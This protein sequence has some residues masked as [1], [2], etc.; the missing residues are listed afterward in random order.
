SYADSDTL[1]LG[2]TEY[3]RRARERILA[4]NPGYFFDSPNP[5]LGATTNIRSADGSPLFGPGTANF[6]SVPVGYAGGGGLAPL[7][8]HAGQ[9]NLESPRTAQYPGGAETHVLKGSRNKSAAATVRR[10][11]SANVDAFVELAAAEGDSSY[12]TIVGLNTYT[13]PADA[14]NNPFGQAVRVTVPLAGAVSQSSASNEDRRVMGGVIVKLPGRWLAEADYT[15]SEASLRIV[16]P[17]MAFGAIGPISSGSIDV[18]RDL[19]AYPV[20]FASY[21]SPAGVNGP[22]RSTLKDATVRF[23]GPLWAL[24]AGPMTLAAM[25]E[26]R[27]EILASSRFTGGYF[28]GKSQTVESAYLELKLPL[29]AGSG[30]P[31][32]EPALELQL[33]GRYDDYSVTGATGYVFDGSGVE[34]ERL[35]AKTSST[36][37]MVGLRYQPLPDVMLRA[38]WGTGFLPPNVSQIF[39]NPPDTQLLTDGVDPLR[40]NSA[41]GP[42]VTVYGGN[43]GLTP[44]ESESFSVGAVLRPRFLEAWRLSVDYSRIKKTDNITELTAQ[45]TIDNENILPGRIVRGERLPDDPIGWAGPITLLDVSLLNISRAEVEAYDI[46]LDYRLDTEAHGAFDFYLL[47]TWQTHYKTQVVPTLPVEE[48]IGVTSNSPLKF[49]SNAGVSWQHG[50]WTLGWSGRYYDSYQVAANPSTSGAVAV[51]NQGGLHVSRQVYHDLFASYRFELEGGSRAASLLDGTQLQ[52]SIKNV[53][54][55]MPPFDAG[56]GTAAPY[57]YSSFGD[58]RGATYYLALKKT[59]GR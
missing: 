50:A 14:A 18:L 45:Q 2:N 56:R 59:F 8:A 6:T 32:A 3:A 15:W 44:E 47:G 36:N 9:Y 41:A 26:H 33:A 39:P 24:P 51:A 25:L 5:P 17:R 20:D 54:D 35:T 11:F 19:N 16:E 10:Q 1:S 53:F 30:L 58:P 22:H 43:P 21:L 48:N 31:G 4:N 23:A 27:D 7:Q 55:E 38:S 37:P 40:G 12:P 29:L 42:Y 13:L 57:Y 52:L 46:A 49:K 34:P 28:P